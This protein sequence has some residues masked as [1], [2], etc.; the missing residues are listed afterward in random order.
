MPR[1]PFLPQIAAISLAAVSLAACGEAVKVDRNSAS[2]QSEENVAD[3][4]T[5]GT[6]AVRIGELGASFKACVADGT[7][8]NVGQGETLPVRAA[9]FDNGAQ[10]GAISAGSK[11]FVCS[12]S[13]DQKWFGVVY[14]EG[15]GLEA[16]CGVSEPVE[17]AQ[18][19]RGN[20]RSG[21][22]AS[23]FVKLVA[24]MEPP[25]PSVQP[26]VGEAK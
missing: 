23:D 5:G 3:A 9:P 6:M 24:G 16:R 26:A 4:V 14:D 1:Y 20:C 12:R 25:V 13:L 11:F 7:T 21:W 10:N 2:A 18:S 15:A 8:R 19:Y 22:V 17:S